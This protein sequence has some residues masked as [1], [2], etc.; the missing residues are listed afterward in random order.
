MGYIYG[1]KCPLKKHIVYIGLTRQ[2]L[3]QRLSKHISSTK[4]KIG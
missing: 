2:S 4:S 3:K 1:L